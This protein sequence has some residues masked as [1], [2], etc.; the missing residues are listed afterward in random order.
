MTRCGGW[1]SPPL[2]VHSQLIETLRDAQR[3]GFFGDRDIGEAVEHSRAFAD[4]LGPLAAGTRLLDLGSGGGL[5][6]LVLADAYPEASIVL[7]DRRQ[8]RTDFLE[9]AVLRLGWQHVT[10]RAA[11]VHR[12]I[13][14]VSQGQLE[15]FDVVTA[16]GF[17][18][19][20]VTLRAAVSLCRPGGW[21][22]ISEPPSGDRWSEGLLAELGLTGHRFG[23]V[24]RFERSVATG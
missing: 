18:P 22:V 7:L 6:G 13:H 12:L 19:P 5:P 1:S 2:D 15:R 24:R 23:A 14:E 16:R 17:G 8:K 11:D 9:R 3:F 20:E 21:I 10:V 4:A